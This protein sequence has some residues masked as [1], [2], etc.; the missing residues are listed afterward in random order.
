MLDNFYKYILEQK[1]KWMYK[2][3]HD[4]KA[5]FKINTQVGIGFKHVEYYYSAIVEKKLYVHKDALRFLMTNGG[6]YYGDSKEQ[7]ELKFNSNLSEIRAI[8][9]SIDEIFQF[10]R[11]E[12]SETPLYPKL[13]M[14]SESFFVLEAPLE[15]LWEP[16]FNLRKV[17]CSFLVK[18]YNLFYKK[19]KKIFSPF[20]RELSGE[21]FR[22]KINGDLKIFDLAKFK[23]HE[24]NRFVIYFS[25]RMKLNKLFVLDA[26]MFTFK[27]TMLV[28]F[29]LDF[30]IEGTE[31]IN[32]K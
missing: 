11:G 4:L 15:D 10:F 9:L 7:Q 19:Q 26:S 14:E 16:L 20:H 24:N 23:F 22:N 28:P 30:E 13:I 32:L 17:D 29:E 8:D 31:V 25:D 3:A 5:D 6:T 1:V 12:M 27:K 2:F 21:I 18:E